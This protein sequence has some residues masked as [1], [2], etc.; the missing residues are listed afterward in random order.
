MKP[1]FHPSLVN[2]PFGDP[3]L[4]IDFLHEKRAVLFD[5]GDLAPL[6]AKKLLRISH[7]FVSHTHM[8]HFIGLD[9]LLR[10]SLGREKQLHLYGPAG[11]VDQVWH[12]L[13]GYTWN[14]VAGYPVEFV[15]TATELHPDG[16]TVTTDF[17]CRAAF[18]GGNTV[19]ASAPG[20]LLLD[21]ETFGIRAVCLDHGGIPCL[22]FALEEKQ[23]VNILKNR[24]AE[25]GLPV[26]PWLTELRRAVLHGEPDDRPFR[27]WWK[28]EGHVTER[29]VP[30]GEVKRDLLQVV[31]GQK[32]GYVTD[33][34]PSPDNEAKIVALV[35]GADYLFIET[36]FS[37][38]D[39]ERA[40]ARSHLTA[41]QAGILGRR[42]GAVRVIPFHFSPRYTGNEERLRADLAAGLGTSS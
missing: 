11:F 3:G 12:R 14:L 4:F 2:G 42:S 19:V 20:G 38:E 35:A 28:G 34:H 37:R 36:P 1:L 41:Y 30:L 18:R 5:L 7:V 13:A 29:L 23:H 22:A 21:E 26:G 39:E 24:L 27:I 31:A 17:R 15:V 25:S 33:A 10:V 8:D 32:I 6:P 40:A 16:K 9:Q